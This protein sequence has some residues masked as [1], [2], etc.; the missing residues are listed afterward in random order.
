MLEDEAKEMSLP[1]LIKLIDLAKKEF[2]TQAKEAL[3]NAKREFLEVLNIDPKNKAAKLHV[4]RCRLYETTNPP[5]ES[6][7]GVWKLTEK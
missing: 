3:K 4:D 1:Q 6:W 7:D 5:S 2:A